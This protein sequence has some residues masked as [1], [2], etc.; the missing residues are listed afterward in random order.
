MNY[1]VADLMDESSQRRNHPPAF[2]STPLRR[3]RNFL[4]LSGT[5][6]T[7]HV[8]HKICWWMQGEPAPFTQGPSRLLWPATSRNRPNFRLPFGSISISMQMC[9]H[10]Q[11]TKQLGSERSSKGWNWWKDCSTPRA[12]SC[13]PKVIAKVKFNWGSFGPRKTLLVHHHLSWADAL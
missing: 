8:A 12:W 4:I 5:H 1:T 9:V 3:L 10:H 2:S 6:L 13:F 11:R 7:L